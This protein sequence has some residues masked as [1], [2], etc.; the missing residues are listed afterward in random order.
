MESRA[1]AGRAGTRALWVLYRISG[2]FSGGGDQF[3][4]HVCVGSRDPAVAPQGVRNTVSED[5]FLV[6]L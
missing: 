1:A 6:R 5:S 2:E 4:S 3:G